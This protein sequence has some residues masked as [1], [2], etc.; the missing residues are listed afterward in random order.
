MV[1]HGFAL[2]GEGTKITN[3]VVPLDLSVDETVHEIVKQVFET[4]RTLLPYLILLGG[5]M[6]AP[7]P[8]SGSWPARCKPGKGPRAPGSR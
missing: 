3:A 5:V 7:V 2:L 4:W 8:A 6:I 1:V